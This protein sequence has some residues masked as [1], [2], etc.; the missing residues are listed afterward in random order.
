MKNEIDFLGVA[1]VHNQLARQL[2]ATVK[3]L[4]DAKVPADIVIDLQDAIEHHKNFA[5][6]MANGWLDQQ[7]NET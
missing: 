3:Q 5:Y 7:E 1:S 2:E 4:Q 6:S